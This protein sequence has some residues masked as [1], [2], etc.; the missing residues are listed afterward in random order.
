MLRE[1]KNKF[2]KDNNNTIN[3]RIKLILL[4]TGVMLYCL[5]PS[6]AQENESG[7]GPIP[8][9]NQNP[10]YVLF[11]N[12]VPE[13]TGTQSSE[14]IDFDV[15]YTMANV[16]VREY[17]YPPVNDRDR[18]ELDM[19]IHKLDL[20]FS[21][22]LGEQ[23]ELELGLPFLFFWEGFLDSFVEVAEDAIHATSP[24]AREDW[25]TNS[26][27]YFVKYD[28]NVLV[29][30][31]D[32]E[33][34]LGDMVCSFK[35]RLTEDEGR[36]PSVALRTSLKLP[37]GSES[38]LLGS[39]QTDYSLGL[40][41]QKQY[42]RAVTYLNTDVIF[43]EKPDVFG[44]MPF[45]DQIISGFLGME[46]LLSEKTSLLFQGGA[47]TSPFPGVDQ[48]DVLKEAPI[49]AGFGAN[50]KLSD[51]VV[52]QWGFIENITASWPDITLQTN[53]KWKF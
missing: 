28:N 14:K 40:I 13:G 19:E 48:V 47:S 31:D 15:R 38:K 9:T 50:H 17:S 3:N 41:L 25:G 46:Y 2:K 52:L 39:G 10:L 4:L 18:I 36:L 27:K 35:Y 43:I 26:Y 7:L 44:T 21:Y 37:T 8:V 49:H 32:N 5:L 29:N 1:L 30:R 33:G 11:L 22:G 23:M 24:S 6:Y 16:N 34:G 20:V 42:G 51:S 45:D 12:P 53:L